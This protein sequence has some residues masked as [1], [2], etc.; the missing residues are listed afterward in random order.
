M[1]CPAL[2]GALLHGTRP[3][4]QLPPHP[5]LLLLLTT[6]SLSPHWHPPQVML[7]YD[8]DGDVGLDELLHAIDDAKSAQESIRRRAGAGGVESPVVGQVLRRVAAAIGP[9]E[10][11]CW[12]GLFRL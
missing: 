4:P 6:P 5:L 8:G 1:P 2:S 12:G 9:S 3:P 10:V 11:C 7:D